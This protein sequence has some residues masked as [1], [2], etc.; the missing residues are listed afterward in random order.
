MA[1]H[2]SD[3]NRNF[4]IRKTL[5]F[6]A[7]IALVTSG[8]VATYAGFLDTGSS[9]VNVQ[10]GTIDLTLDGQQ[11]NVPVNFGND[12]RPGM[13]SVQKTIRV[14]NAGSIPMNWSVKA[15][16]GAGPLAPKLRTVLTVGSSTLQTT[17][18]SSVSTSNRILAAGAEEILTLTVT[19]P[20]ST[21][22]N[23]F[24]GASANTTLVFTATS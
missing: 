18:L 8:A 11:T 9:T 19:W 10:A 17:T 16:T 3:P 21:T 23:E 1:R 6:S 24:Q 13:A 22:D 4:F 14:K 15:A 5:V 2:R 7:S 20:P 12:L